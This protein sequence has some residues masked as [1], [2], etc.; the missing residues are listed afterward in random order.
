MVS[1]KGLYQE[2]EFK[3]FNKNECKPLLI[4]NFKDGPLMTLVNATFSLVKVET[5]TFNT[6][7]YKFENHESICYIFLC[8][9]FI[10]GH[11]QIILKYARSKLYL[12]LYIRC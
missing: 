3:F 5:S 10:C 8:T 6:L 12:E 9:I 2:I 1:L 4:F 7:Q 11:R